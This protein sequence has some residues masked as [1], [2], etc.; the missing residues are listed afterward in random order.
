MA[1]L[2]VITGYSIALL[3]MPFRMLEYIHLHFQQMLH[4]ISIA[5]CDFCFEP[6][7]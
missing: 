5:S 7:F 1:D 4:G 3:F 6:Q 2:P